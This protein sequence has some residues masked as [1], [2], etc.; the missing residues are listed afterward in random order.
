MNNGFI[1]TII[2]KLIDK[3]ITIALCESVTGG[4]ICSQITSVPDASKIF[5]G[6]VVVYSN[7]VKENIL[8]VRHATL[9]KYSSVSQECSEEL[10]NNCVRKFHTD[11]AI[12]ITGNAGPKTIGKNDVGV[13]FLSIIVIDKT[14]NFKLISNQKER[15]EIRADFTAQTFFHL[16]KIIK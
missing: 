3:K 8:S 16:E 11:I 10:A 4:M 2:Q 5:K 7:E 14:Y 1:T 13:G 15:N 9:D 6:G 12:A